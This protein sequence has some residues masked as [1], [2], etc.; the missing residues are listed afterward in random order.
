VL[1]KV[2]RLDQE[3]VDSVLDQPVEALLVDPQGKSLAVFIS[4]E[5]AL[6]VH[7]LSMRLIVLGDLLVQLVED[8]RNIAEDL[9]DSE[10][11]EKILAVREQA[12]LNHINGIRADY[13]K[14]VMEEISKLSEELAGET[15]EPEQVLSE[16]MRRLS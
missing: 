9:K 5:E 15:Y 3:T 16:L 6:R 2:Q 10:A 1:Y 14:D 8:V 12:L 7:R 11:S 4:E 13:R